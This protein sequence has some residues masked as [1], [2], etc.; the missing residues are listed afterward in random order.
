M[1]IKT[2]KLRSWQQAVYDE[3][4]KHM[5]MRESEVYAGCSDY[6]INRDLSIIT[7]FPKG[8]GHSFL[9][10][11]I[12]ATMPSI[13]VYKDLNHYT[14]ATGNFPV[15]TQTDA[16]S[17]FEIF[18]ALHKPDVRVPN[19]E[20]MEIRQRMQSKRV[21]VVDN[22]MSLPQGIKDFLYESSSGIII[23]LGH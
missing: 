21:T 13:L 11:Y 12:A 1:D 23:M 22:F 8:S 18:Y 9:A 7:A 5:E 20:Y 14:Q 10:N 4:E 2:V 15:H 16:L 17:I 19:P 3:I 6:Q